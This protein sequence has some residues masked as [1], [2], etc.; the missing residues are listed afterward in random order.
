MPS[1]CSQHSTAFGPWNYALFFIPCTILLLMASG[2]YYSDL[3]PSDSG[4]QCH[5]QPS[6]QCQDVHTP[7]MPFRTLS[8]P[9]TR[10]ACRRTGPGS[11]FWPCVRPA[12]PRSLGPAS[13]F[14]AVSWL[15]RSL[16]ACQLL[17]ES[18]SVS[19]SVL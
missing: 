10:D 8:L 5:S 9:P 4:I 15:S 3:L 19:L 13:G 16:S 18:L 17:Q 2:I 12:V 1:G 6:T 14:P 7:R 11:C